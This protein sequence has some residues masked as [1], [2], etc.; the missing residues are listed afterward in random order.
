MLI[1]IIQRTDITINGCYNLT[2][3]QTF[4]LTCLCYKFE[5]KDYCISDTEIYFK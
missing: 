3:N 5:L 1:V 2:D 4:P